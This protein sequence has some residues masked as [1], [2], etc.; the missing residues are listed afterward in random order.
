MRKLLECKFQPTKR[1]YNCGY[2]SFG[3]FL[4]VYL[5][6]FVG[7]WFL[8]VSGCTRLGHHLLRWNPFIWFYWGPKG[9]KE[10]WMDY[11]T[12]RLPQSSPFPRNGRAFGR[13]RTAC[14]LPIYH[15]SQRLKKEQW[16]LQTQGLEMMKLKGKRWIGVGGKKRSFF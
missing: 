8:E 7:L 12:W 10:C 3:K 2:F 4:F 11:T 14:S 5:H 15:W 16:G 1:F 13:L 9:R 6:Q